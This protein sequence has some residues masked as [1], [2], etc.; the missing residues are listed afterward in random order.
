MTW[1]EHR[2]PNLTTI[3]YTGPT[4]EEYMWPFKSTSKP[5]KSRTAGSRE[6]NDCFPVGP[7]ALDSRLPTTVQL[8]PFT[9]AELIALDRDV[10]FV[11][12]LVAWAPPVQ[13]ED[14]EWNVVLGLVNGVIYKIS[15][16][17]NGARAKVG[18]FHRYFAIRCN[19][20]FSVGPNI[21]GAQIWD[22]K[23]GNICVDGRNL[24]GEAIVT[25]TLTSNAIAGYPRET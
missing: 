19:R 22:A 10:T 17:F 3:G 8:R 4:C 23:N 7:Y 25:V 13:F 5:V 9:E 21:G 15:L 2:V 18:H 16:Q 14:L 11:G 12:E 24:G 6:G 1:P 20:D